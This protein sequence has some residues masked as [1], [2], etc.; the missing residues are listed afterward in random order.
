M[1]T[2]LSNNRKVIIASK[3]QVISEFI[4]DCVPVVVLFTARFDKDDSIESWGDIV[5]FFIENGAKYIVCVG[6]LSESLHDSIDDFLYAMDDDNNTNIS[7]DIIT[8]YHV[9]EDCSETIDYFAYATD[10]GEVEN[11]CMV[12]VLQD[13]KEDDELLIALKKA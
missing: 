6:S 2:K 7:T 8:T 1:Y 9:D 11:A 3:Q 10:M 5:K 4:E 13:T 12:A